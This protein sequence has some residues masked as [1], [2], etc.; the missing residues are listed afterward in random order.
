MSSARKHSTLEGSVQLCKE[1]DRNYVVSTASRGLG[2]EFA[3]Q[4]LS[5][6][7]GHVICFSRKVDAPSLVT[8]KETFKTRISIVELDLES[9]PSIDDAVS[10]VNDICVQRKQVGNAG[11]GKV[12]ILLNVAALL[13]DQSKN[14]PGP[15]RSILDVDRDW[16]EKTM[17]VNF[18]GHVMVTKGLAPLLKRPK[19]VKLGKV[20]NLSARVGS[21]SD[22]FLGGWMS[23]RCSKSAINQFTKTVSLELKRSNCIAISIHPGKFKN[24]FASR[25]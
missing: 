21:I 14:A 5:R 6:T 2:L 11:S 15:E 9:Q 22:N 3:R 1:E 24:R 10:R 18:V 8:L 17:S 13:G 23:Y 16:L 4:L 19:N 25:T 12:D 7:A 20:V